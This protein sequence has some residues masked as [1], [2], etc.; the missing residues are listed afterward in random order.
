MISTPTVAHSIP[1]VIST[2]APTRAIS[3]WHSGEMTTIGAVIGS[4]STPLST[5]L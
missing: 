5:A 4:T 1:V 3:R 2:F